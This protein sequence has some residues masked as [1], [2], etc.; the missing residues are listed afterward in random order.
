MTLVVLLLCFGGEESWLDVGVVDM[1][2][3]CDDG[4]VQVG[5]DGASVVV[6]T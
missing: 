2:R 6:E 5:N 3:L 4:F 1:V